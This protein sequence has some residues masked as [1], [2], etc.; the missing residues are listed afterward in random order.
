MS[1]RN[2][3]ENKKLLRALLVSDANEVNASC[4]KNELIMK[5]KLKKKVRSK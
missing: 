3:K 2:K 1:F 4:D 5:V